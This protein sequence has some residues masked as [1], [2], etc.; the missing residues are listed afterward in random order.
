[1]KGWECPKCSKVHAP[2]IIA[3]DCH[4]GLGN[5]FNYPKQIIPPAGFPQCTC[6][7]SSLHCPVHGDINRVTCESRP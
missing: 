6:N 3:C 1:M 5:P 4:I 2:F 7:T